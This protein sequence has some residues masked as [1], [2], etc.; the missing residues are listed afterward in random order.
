MGMSESVDGIL[1]QNHVA[2]LQLP[3][4]GLVVSFLPDSIADKL[5]GTYEATVLS[6]KPIATSLGS[7]DRDISHTN[8]WSI[9][10]VLNS[11]KQEHVTL[12]VY[13]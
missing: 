10:P 7:R 11:G 5:S 8:L 9:Y 12:M 4:L 1:S 3:Q 13:W 2:S 6:Q